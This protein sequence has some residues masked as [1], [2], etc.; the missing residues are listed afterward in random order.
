[1]ATRKHGAAEARLGRTPGYGVYNLGG[2]EPVTLAQ[3]VTVVERVVGRPARR[4]W[5]PPQTGDVERT[6]A[7]LTRSTQELGYRPEVTLEQ[8]I[9]RQWAWMRTQGAPG[10]GPAA[11][12]LG[13]AR[14]GRGA[15]A[16]LP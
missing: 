12:G 2:R 15:S 7:D 5:L 6:C 13:L 8:G 11:A 3:L 16:A 1:M 10:V 9:A 4:Q 14:A